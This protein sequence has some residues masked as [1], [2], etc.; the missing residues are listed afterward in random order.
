MKQDLALRVLSEIMKWDDTRARDEFAWLRLIS[1]LKY[2]SYRDFVAGARFLE[3]LAD[4]LQQFDQTEREAAY[5][6]IRRNLVFIG[7]LEMQHL[8]E[9]TYPETVQKRLFASVAGRLNIPTYMVLA[10]PDARK[11]YE[12]L[13]RKTLFLGLSDGARIDDFRRANSGIISNEQVV[14]ATQINESKWG[15]LLKDLRQNLCDENAKFAFVYLVDDFMGSGTTLLRERNGVWDG[16]LL[17]FWEEN[18]KVIQNSFEPDWVLCVHHYI[19]T[20]QVSVAIQDRHRAALQSRGEKAWFKNVE[21]SFGTILPKD[22]PI[23]E[24]RHGDFLKLV[25]KY[26][27]PSIETLHTRLGGTDVRLGFG[28]CGLPLV[29]E[30]NTPNNS[31]ALL[32]AD[33]TGDGGA[34]PMRPLFRR[35]Q[36]HT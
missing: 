25:N 34:H 18:Q 31:V 30:H 13:L 11:T 14:I 15:A 5:N 10:Q 29:L 3:S 33:T 20:Y 24:G 35:K 7:P 12:A 32:W 4:W 6:F 1:R 16:R 23:D 26:Y 27:D 8:V 28:S 2:D 36:R 19:G 22:L 21:F 9:H 17:R